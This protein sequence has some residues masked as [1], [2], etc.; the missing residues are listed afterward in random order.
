MYLFVHIVSFFIQMQCIYATYKFVHD[1]MQKRK[2]FISKE[3][4]PLQRR[5]FELEPRIQYA[6]RS[7]DM[8]HANHLTRFRM[9]SIS[10]SS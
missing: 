8:P 10:I 6:R 4:I 1:R 5:S 7:L 2:A 9:D 3:V